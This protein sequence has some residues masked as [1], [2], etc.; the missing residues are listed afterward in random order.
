MDIANGLQLSFAIMVF[1]GL[2]GGW[3]ASKNP[4]KKFISAIIYHVMFFTGLIGS[5]VMIVAG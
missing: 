1:A 2:I 4:I 3:I 5:W